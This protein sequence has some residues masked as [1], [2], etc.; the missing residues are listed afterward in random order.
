MSEFTVQSWHTVH[1]HI[2][3]LYPVQNVANEQ[4]NT[5]FPTEEPFS[6]YVY[7]VYKHEAHRKISLK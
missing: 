5:D 7:P 2:L 6:A 1:L 3:K 4:S